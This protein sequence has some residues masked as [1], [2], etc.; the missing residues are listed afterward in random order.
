MRNHERE[1]T[2]LL[3]NLSDREMREMLGVAYFLTW[4]HT[5]KIYNPF[6]RSPMSILGLML[7]GFRE[8]I[9]TRLR[10][11]GIYG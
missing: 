7:I 2:N 3:R 6:N 4:W 5:R 10:T 11:R 8:V 9:L 1:L